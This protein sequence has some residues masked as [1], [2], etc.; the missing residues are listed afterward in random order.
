[1]A[2]PDGALWFTETGR[3]RIGRMTTSGAIT[4]YPVPTTSSQLGDI[5]AGPDA[6]MWFTETKSNRVGRA[7]RVGDQ[8]I[9]ARADTLD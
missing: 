2:G 7:R 1:V 8:S 9:V 5:L 6:A 4:D 3:D